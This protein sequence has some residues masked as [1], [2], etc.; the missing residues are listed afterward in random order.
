MRR[1]RSGAVWLLGLAVSGSAAAA[2]GTATDQ[3]VSLTY[4]DTH[5]RPLPTADLLGVDAAG[6]PVVHVGFWYRVEGDTREFSMPAPDSETYGNG[7]ITAVWNDLDGKGFMVQEDTWVFDNEGP[8]GGFVT[9]LWAMNNNSTAK[10]F[11][12]FH[13][14]DAD[15]AGTSSNDV[16]TLA[17]SW[18]LKFSDGASRL[19]YRAFGP[20]H[21]QVADYPTLHTALRDALVTHLDDT[22]LPFGPGNATAAFEFGPYV[23]PAGG[24]LSPAMVSVF[25]NPARDHVKG[26]RYGLF[27][28]PPLY[29]QKT[30][31]S[32]AF[33]QGMRRTSQSFWRAYPDAP[34]TASALVGVDDFFGALR[35]DLVYRDTVTG[36][37][38]VNLNAITGAPTLPLNWKISA[39]GDFNADGK[40]DILWRNTTSQKLVVWTMSGQ[41]KIGNIIPSPAQAVDANWEVAAAVDFN[42]DGNRDLLWYNQTTGKLVLWFMDASVVRI[43]GQFTNPASVGNN[44][45]RV[46]AVG[47]YGKGPGGVYD[48]QDIVWQ[49]DTSKKVVVWFMDLAGNR[50]SGTFISPDTLAG[51]W[52]LV[53]PR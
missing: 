45:W 49:N 19:S 37:A 11:T 42:G 6:D 39:T 3:A 44:N 47:D 33:H 22:G 52:D 36:V 7:V 53:G 48:T 32:D 10:Q 41:A 8:S 12:V 4:I 26:D 25:F 29:A 43:T 34:T 13:Y 14:L 5:W 40:A 50:T 21:Y 27:G 46:L 30:D 35:A 9:R 18:L 15:L 17:E 28:Q 51:G 23:V 20:L 16:G 1:L 24:T 38:Y 2:G 31:L